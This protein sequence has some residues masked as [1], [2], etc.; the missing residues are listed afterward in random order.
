[1]RV[2]PRAAGKMKF[3]F[4]EPQ[5]VS[6]RAKKKLSALK[7]RTSAGLIIFQRTRHARCAV[8]YI[9]FRAKFLRLVR[10]RKRHAAARI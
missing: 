5:E 6:T 1:M 2:C 7:I 4:T 9:Y 10:T 8:L 3:I